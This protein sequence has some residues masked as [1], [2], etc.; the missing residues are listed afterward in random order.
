MTMQA[1][2]GSTAF[3][4]LLSL[5][6]AVLLNGGAVPKNAEAREQWSGVKCLVAGRNV[7]VPL[8]QVTEI[9]EARSLTAIPGC[10]TWVKGLM[11]VRGRLLPVFGVSEFFNGGRGR[12]GTVQVIVVEQGAIFC[13]IAV[14][15]VFG[16]QKFFQDDFSENT[17]LSGSA[18]D[19][20]G[21]YAGASTVIDNDSWYQL[22]VCGLATRMSHANPAS[23][24][25]SETRLDAPRP[26]TDVVPGQ[27]D[28][29]EQTHAN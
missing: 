11:N 16:I 9:L 10:A 28:K 1:L 14:D 25:A 19:G 3:N 18:L 24:V 13:G 17:P 5:E 23:A 22:D 21:E 26:R 20:V 6:E 4:L 29:T 27:P 8:Q 2:T 12:N 7:I 15:K